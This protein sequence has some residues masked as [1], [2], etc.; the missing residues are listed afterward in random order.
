MSMKFD[1]CSYHHVVLQISQ[2]ADVPYI[3]VDLSYKMRYYTTLALRATR[4]P[5]TT[6]L[7]SDKQIAATATK[8]YADF[9]KEQE[10]D[11]Y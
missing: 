3:E 6:H 7:V 9:K 10:E 2:V 11:V 1:R 5:F 8:N 4:V